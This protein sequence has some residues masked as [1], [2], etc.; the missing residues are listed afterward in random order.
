MREPT[1]RE[2]NL[3]QQHNRSITNTSSY[4][5]G[6]LPAS[7]APRLQLV[8]VVI[9][10]Q[11][12]WGAARRVS[13]VPDYGHIRDAVTR[14]RQWV[15]IACFTRPAD[16]NMARRVWGMFRRAGFEPNEWIPV[17]SNGR[18][19]TDSDPI[20]I[21]SSMRLLYRSGVDELVIV[22]A[23]SDLRSVVDEAHE[24]GSRVVLARFR[25]QGAA[26]MD[27]A[28]DEVVLLG[29]EHLLAPAIRRAA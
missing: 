29:R 18:L 8:G 20:V 27:A 4:V 26:V 1:R 24:L 19:K 17:S 5:N 28:V 3:D 16:E 10:S 6:R 15:G 13:G 2:Q 14:G 21:T 23:D 12:V 25:W 9:D 7:R 11:N 22:G